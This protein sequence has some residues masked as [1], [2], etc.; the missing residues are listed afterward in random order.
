MS[1]RSKI[2][3][4]IFQD[5]NNTYFPKNEEEVSI[6]IKEFYK[7][8]LPTEI[9]GTN[10]K[11][12]IGNKTQTSNKI[13]LSKLTG[14][15]DY[16]P[17]ELYIKVKAGTLL[18]DVEKAL[19][20]NNQ[21]LAFEPIDFGFI[22]NGQSNKGTVAGYLSC[23]YAGSRRFKVGSVRDHVL[24]FKGVN[25]KG[26]IIKS[27]GTVVKNVT[28]YDLSKLITGSFG[29][30]C[31]LTEITLKVLPKKKFSNTIVIDAKNNQL[32]YDLFNKIS[33]SSSEV[34][35]AVF[36]PEEPKDDSYLKNR[37]KIFKFNDLDFKGSFLAFRVEGDKISINEKIKSLTEELQLNTYKT[38][39]LDSYQSE[40][41]WKKINNLELFE[42]TKNNLVRIVIEPSNGSKMMRY[43]SNKFKY[44]IDWCGSLF[45]I[46]MPAK[47]N[48]KI[49]EI[50]K[51]TKEHGGYLTIIKASPEYDYEESIFTIDDVRLMISKKIKQSFDPKRILNPGKMYRGV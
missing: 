43:L 31:V 15:I 17:E 50:K 46:E 29:T 51:I 33:G 49:K 48:M 27:G 9:I 42:K 18:E 38:F 3:S 26:D 35:G 36:I 34:S 32:I 40:P 24:G 20:K 6:L 7:K 44:Y 2:N 4:Q 41:F 12:F 28:G 16:F 25:G 8:N 19:E 30:L 13:S 21:E 22:E 23:N 45:W 37:D 1:I 5:S 39:L 47:K 14:I 10:T 11:N